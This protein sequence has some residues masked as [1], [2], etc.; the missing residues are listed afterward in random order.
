MKI[1]DLTPDPDNANKGTARGESA[2]EDSISSYGLGRSILIDKNN[3]IIA[4]NKTAQKAGELGLDE[5][6]VVETTG[7]QV[8]AV[9]RTDLDLERDP[10]ARMLAYTDNRTSE[11]DLDWD[12]E[13]LAADMERLDL[14]S[15]FM[16][17][18]IE[19][20]LAINEIPD[21]VE[22]LAKEHGSGGVEDVWPEIRVRVPEETRLRFLAWLASFD[23]DEDHDRLAAMMDGADVPMA[24]W[25][26]EQDGP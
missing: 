1:T 12:V 19:D 23:G 4:G 24:D 26:A 14:T 16:K 21:T 7:H 17:V 15:V 2:L 18:E 11:L 25:V 20:L 3:R 13:Q 10:D 6:T 9:K 8:V 5:V 22:E